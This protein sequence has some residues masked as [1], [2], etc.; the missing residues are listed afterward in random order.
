VPAP[1]TALVNG[2]VLKNQELLNWITQ[3]F[4]QV[5]EDEL[6]GTS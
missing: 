4:N 1:L 6:K 5:F 2:Q 3:L